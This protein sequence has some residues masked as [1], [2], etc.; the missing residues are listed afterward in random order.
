MDL[1]P[2]VFFAAFSVLAGPAFA[3]T[4]PAGAPSQYGTPPQ[5]EGMETSSGSEAVPTADPGVTNSV[6]D[7]EACT[8]TPA[9]SAQRPKTPGSQAE[10]QPQARCNDKK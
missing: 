8:T 6:T 5:N 7:K 9:T 10:P 2:L 1:R 4:P 3:Q